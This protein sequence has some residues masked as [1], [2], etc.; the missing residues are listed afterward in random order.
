MNNF[1]EHAFLCHH[2]IPKMKWGVR[3]YQNKDGSLTPLGRI[4]YGKHSVFNKINDVRTK[5][6]PILSKL[7]QKYAQTGANLFPTAASFNAL[8]V[9]ELKAMFPTA[10]EFGKATGQIQPVT[11]RNNK[12]IENIIQNN[13]QLQIQTV[14]RINQENIM[15]MQ[16]DNFRNQMS[17]GNAM[18]ALRAG[19]MFV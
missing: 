7:Q 19:G 18:S 13:S 14:N 11:I 17:Y 6:F 4:R 16:L 15:R 1:T 10:Y 8:M 9:K 3:R 12:K 5:K 2:G